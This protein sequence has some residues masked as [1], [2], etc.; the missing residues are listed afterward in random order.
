MSI[1]LEEYKGWK[2][3]RI[4]IVGKGLGAKPYWAGK[5]AGTPEQKI[6]GVFASVELLKQWID[7]Q[8]ERPWIGGP[9]RSEDPTQTPWPVNAPP[10][11]TPEPVGPPSPAIV[12]PTPLQV[13]ENTESFIEEYQGWRIYQVTSWPPMH[14]EYVAYLVEEQYYTSETEKALHYSQTGQALHNVGHVIHGKNVKEVKIQIETYGQLARQ[15][16]LTQK[17]ISENRLMLL[18]GAMYSS[19][20]GLSMYQSYSWDT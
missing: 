3:Y 4:Q 18:F 17:Y 5:N 14:V 7:L 6:S 12:S 11:V 20:L 2:I 1:F 16:Y 13:G 15:A 8:E 19:L 10:L 9:P